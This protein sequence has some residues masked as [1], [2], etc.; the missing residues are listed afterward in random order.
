MDCL[1]LTTEI[2]EIAKIVPFRIVL[3]TQLEQFDVFTI[4]I[5][6][7]FMAFSDY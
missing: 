4:N 6:A 7:F 5:G 3:R 2:M 1:I